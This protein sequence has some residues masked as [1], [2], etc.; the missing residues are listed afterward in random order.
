MCEKFIAK[1]QILKSISVY[2]IVIEKEFRQKRPLFIKTL[3]S[4]HK[5]KELF[6]YFIKRLFYL[7]KPSAY[8]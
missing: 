1:G 4:D 3:N 2:Y 7:V 5:L 6:E 8:G